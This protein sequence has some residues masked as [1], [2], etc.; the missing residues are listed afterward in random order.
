MAQEARLTATITGEVAVGDNPQPANQLTLSIENRGDAIIS[1]SRVPPNLYLKGQLGKGE[2]ALFSKKEDARDYCTIVKPDGWEYEWAFP[3]DEAFSLKLYTYNDTL[4]DKGASISIKLRQSHFED[5]AGPGRI[6][7]PMPR[8]AARR[9]TGDARHLD[10]FVGQGHRR[11]GETIALLDA[12]PRRR[13][14]SA[15][16]RRCRW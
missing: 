16:R 7:L 8:N 9:L 13:R 14:A 1:E 15:A 12:S 3:S 6:K 10:A 2:A 5:R 11:L 4:F